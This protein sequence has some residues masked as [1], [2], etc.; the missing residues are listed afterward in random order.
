M[1]WETV[2]PDLT[3]NDPAHQKQDDSGGLTIDATQAENHNTV[4]TI[5]PSTLQQGVIWVGTDD[6]NVQLTRDGGKTWTNL[7]SRIPGLPK[8]AWIPQITASRHKAGEAFVVANL[9]RMGSDLAPYIYRTTDFGQ[10][11]TRIMSEKEAKGYAL[12]FLQDPTEPRLMFAGTEHG[13]WVSIDEGK[14]WTQWD[15]GMPAATPTMDLAIQE[16]EAD[17][18]IGTFGRSL[19]V[20]DNIRP[21]RKL[22][23]TGGKI[24]EQPLVAFEPSPAYQATY[25]G[26]QGYGKDAEDLY[27]ATNRPAG[28]VLDLYLKPKTA[29]DKVAEPV[30]TVKKSKKPAAV[31]V[32]ATAPAPVLASAPKADSIVVNFYN[33]ANKLV[34][35]LKQAPEHD[36]GPATHRLESDRNR[37]QPAEH[38]GTPARGRSI[39]RQ[40]GF[41]GSLQG[42]FCVCGG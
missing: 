41:T 34:R 30:E 5:A 11:W 35:T 20:L 10:T 19:Y 8:E 1:T 24:L 21:L 6:G 22:A 14:T 28:A 23:A 4:L 25:R 27:Q 3:L 2:S 33:E 31:T 29:I 16:R 38:A 36:A 9:Y 12:C 40:S 18:V 13:L 15:N 37:R 42:G 32:Q 26:P 7:S 39:G 17:L